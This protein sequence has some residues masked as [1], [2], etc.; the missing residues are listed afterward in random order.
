[1]APEQTSGP[2]ASMVD[3]PGGNVVR[4]TSDDALGST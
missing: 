4:L 1:M 2:Y 3:V